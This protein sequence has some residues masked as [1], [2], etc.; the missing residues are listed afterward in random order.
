MFNLP[1]L[2]WWSFFVFAESGLLIFSYSSFVSKWP[3][4]AGF[5]LPG[6]CGILLD[7]LPVG[8]WL[9]FLKVL[10]ESLV[11]VFTWSMSSMAAPVAL[12]G[13][14]CLNPWCL[15]T[16]C[17]DEPAFV[18]RNPIWCFVCYCP[19]TFPPMA[20]YFIWLAIDPLSPCPP[21]LDV[22]FWPGPF[23]FF[24]L[25]CPELAW[26]FCCFMFIK[27]PFVLTMGL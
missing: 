5:E 3:F 20:I 6:R 12:I 10:L 14:P 26:L 24:V 7:K 11:P 9:G 17:A 16:P 21:R 27:P 8:V 13:P 1:Y 25:T 15:S 23:E 4:W 19:V 18:F 22:C 2:L